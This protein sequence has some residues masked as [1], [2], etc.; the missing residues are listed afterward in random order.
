MIESFA[1]SDTIGVAASTRDP[2]EMLLDV[3]DP[4]VL[5]LHPHGLAPACSCTARMRLST[6]AKLGIVRGIHDQPLLR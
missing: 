5:E 1:T 2:V 6:Q 4:E 3:L